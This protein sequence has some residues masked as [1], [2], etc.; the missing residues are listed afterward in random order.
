MV[1]WAT[2]EAGDV[3]SVVVV[4]AGAMTSVAWKASRGVVALVTPL[5]EKITPTNAA[6]TKTRVA[7]K[8]RNLP[9]PMMRLHFRVGHR[10]RPRLLRGVVRG[11]Q[12]M[13]AEQDRADAL[14]THGE[15]GV[16]VIPHGGAFRRL[17]S[18]KD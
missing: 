15:Q 6:T 2:G 8:W 1:P 14:V 5:M 10:I 3:V 16:T 13:D 18:P 11:P 12:A 4:V 7:S 17:L 9:I